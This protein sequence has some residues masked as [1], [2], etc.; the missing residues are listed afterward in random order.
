M[1]VSNSQDHSGFSQNYHFVFNTLNQ[2]PSQAS[3]YLNYQYST[4]D[5]HTQLATAYKNLSRNE[6]DNLVRFFK[7][8][9]GSDRPLQKAQFSL[10][11]TKVQTALPPF[12]KAKSIL[13]QLSQRQITIDRAGYL[14][15]SLVSSC[16]KLSSLVNIIQEITQFTPNTHWDVRLINKLLHKALEFEDLDPCDF[17]GI[18]TAIT[19]LRSNF[20]ARTCTLL[21]QLARLNANILDANKL[22]FGNEFNDSLIRQWGVKLNIS[23]C[24]AF[25]AVC[26]Q[27]ENFELA[28]SLFSGHEVLIKPKSGVTPD[29]ITCLALLKL[30]S[31]TGHFYEAKAL[32]LGDMQRE[33]K[34][35]SL[36]SVWGVKPNIK[37]YSTFIGVCAQTKNFELAWSL[38]DGD[39]AVM[40]KDPTLTPDAV[41][42]INLLTLC[43]KTQNFEAAKLLFLGTEDDVSLMKQ[44]HLEPNTAIC[45]AFIGV[46]AQTG[47]FEDA[48]SLVDGNKAIMKPST[49]LAPNALTCTNLLKLC[50]NTRHFTEAN[51]LFFI[52]ESLM[53]KWNVSRNTAICNAF[54]GV[55]AQSGNFEDAWSLVN[56][57]K[58]I[59]KYGTNLAPDVI[60]CVNLLKLCSE[61]QRF[62]EA[63]ALVLGAGSM[64]NSW[65][66]EADVVIYSAFIDVCT[67]TGNFKPAWSLVY[68]DKAIM[69]PGSPLAPNATTCINLLALCVATKHFDEA[70]KLFPTKE[71]DLGLL[72]LWGVKPNIKLFCAYIEMC[73]QAGDFESAWSLVLGD[74]AVVKPDSIIAPDA[75]ACLNLLTL[76]AKTKHFA[77]AKEL[78]FGNGEEPSLMNSWGVEPRTAI[79]NAY[80]YVCSQTGNF[81]EAW[82]LV[83]GSPPILKPDTALAANNITC[84]NLLTLC[85]ETNRFSKAKELFLSNQNAPSLIKQWGIDPNLANCCA[86]MSVCEKIGDFES[87]WSLVN[88]G[89]AYLQ[90]GSKLTPDTATFINLLVICG[91]F[92][93]FPEAE[94][95][96]LET[97]SLMQQWGIEPSDDICSAFIDVCAKTGN[98]DS[99][100]N[101]LPKM[102]KKYDFP[103]S[104]MLYSQ[105]TILEED[106]FPSMIE[107]GIRQGLFLPSMGLQGNTLNLH[108]NKI[109]RTTFESG[110]HIRGVSLDFAKLLFSY[111]TENKGHIIT[112]IVT[113]YHGY[114]ILKEG[115]V[116]HLK[117]KYGLNCIERKSDSGTIVLIKA[118]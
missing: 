96:F 41:T 65:R 95:L 50:G 35:P 4:F 14:L 111:L 33:K 114:G 19:N 69:K 49:K 30:C 7:R 97:G 55:C 79:Y 40:K 22:L 92:G 3:R 102:L 87:A 81:D 110:A 83:C 58:A 34:T 99:A 31:T 48:W 47:N 85:K 17:N 37:I 67:Q 56:G 75:V 9:Q 36:M 66:I 118:S 71:G 24:N 32:V 82:S 72:S 78:L 29:T 44:W 93:R 2:N 25:I 115:M 107:T 27:T 101:D 43:D 61:T 42:C 63:S 84:T 54:I 98:F 51:E 108:R 13:E 16:N 90:P 89:N 5:R 38:V 21:L 28:W 8:H 106:K 6:K 57:A 68:G 12:R 117:E 15:N 74:R 62:T 39:E 103:L 91:Q 100:K 60:T 20:E 23:I 94:K 1:A 80:I 105:L 88:G 86:F 45:N 77:E 53:T 64:M 104:P 112:S 70:K 116:S 26:A 46:C 109:F 59:L 76:C 11:N 18:F 10:Y 73:T 113:G 52:K